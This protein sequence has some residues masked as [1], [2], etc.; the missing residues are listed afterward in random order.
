[1]HLKPHR[2]LYGFSPW[3]FLSTVSSPLYLKPE[4]SI[5]FL[6][7]SVFPSLWITVIQPYFPGNTFNSPS[8]SQRFLFMSAPK[9]KVFPKN[10][11]F[12]RFAEAKSSFSSTKIFLC[13]FWTLLHRPFPSRSLVAVTSI[14]SHIILL[15]SLHALLALADCLPSHA[16]PWAN[17][18]IWHWEVNTALNHP[19]N[20]PPPSVSQIYKDTWPSF[21]LFFFLT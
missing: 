3:C 7:S 4:V 11:G 5:I 8:R 1:M 2:V 14:F 9:T 15:S 18:P 20:L 16:P 10:K 6:K 19:W 17:S 12:P 21:L 13:P